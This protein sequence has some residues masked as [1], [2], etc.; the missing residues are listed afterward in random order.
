MYVTEHYAHAGLPTRIRRLSIR[1]HRFVAVHADFGGGEFE[2]K[3][4][5]FAG[6]HLLLNYSTSAAGCV[7]VEVQ[8]EHGRVVPGFGL[9]EM[10]VLFGDH[11]DE[12]H[13]RE[14]RLAHEDFPRPIMPF[15]KM[16]IPE[17]HLSCNKSFSSRLMPYIPLPRAYLFAISNQLTSP[18][19]KMRIMHPPTGRNRN[20]AKCLN[21]ATRI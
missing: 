7:Q 15:D 3:P 19:K 14:H 1:P 13:V 17:Y 18:L 8:D 2:T 10:P 16:L 21:R 6:R 20:I 11:L 9:A 4:F 5:I 12:P